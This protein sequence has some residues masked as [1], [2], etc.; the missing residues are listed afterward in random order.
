[1]KNLE[2]LYCRNTN[3]IGLDGIEDIIYNLKILN[4]DNNNKM[5][6]VKLIYKKNE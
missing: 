3:A 6:Y 4:K 1:M 2:E 5:K